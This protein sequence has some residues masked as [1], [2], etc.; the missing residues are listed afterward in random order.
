MHIYST[1]L[2][3]FL[4]TDLQVVQNGELG[5]NSVLED[6]KELESDLNTHMFTMTPII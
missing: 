6:Q 1:H 2:L 4:F 3:N 5:N